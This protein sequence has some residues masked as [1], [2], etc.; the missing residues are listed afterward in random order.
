MARASRRS[1]WK[2]TIDSPI[3]DLGDILVEA[4][5]KQFQNVT[6]KQDSQTG[7]LARIV[8]R[9]GSNV[10]G[11][12]MLSALTGLT[13]ELRV[14]VGEQRLANATANL[15]LEETRRLN[16]HLSGI[17]QDEAVEHRRA[18]Q[19]RRSG[20]GG[21]REERWEP[22]KPGHPPSLFDSEGPGG[23]PSKSSCVYVAKGINSTLMWEAKASSKRLKRADG[24][25]YAYSYGARAHD[26][27]D[28]PGGGCR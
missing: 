17:R 24:E 21:Q 28:A 7:E 1:R 10:S 12:S 18:R 26:S 27:S 23:P 19:H 14:L 2:L 15:Q 9:L 20:F 25:R 3:E 8:T 5:R 13:T 16:A 6:G 22:L 4:Q 11:D